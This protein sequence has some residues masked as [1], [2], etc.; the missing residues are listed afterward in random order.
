MVRVVIGVVSVAVIGAVVGVAV[1]TAGTNFGSQGTLCA[2]G[3]T[4]GR[5]A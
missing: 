5:L 3:R 2:V 1:V 4:R